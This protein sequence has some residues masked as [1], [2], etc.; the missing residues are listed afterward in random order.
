MSL[1]EAHANAILG[2]VIS[3]SFTYWALPYYGVSQP[4][5]V[6]ATG[7]TVTFFFLSTGRAYLLR[8]L[9]ARF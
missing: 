9:F 2:I 8:R 1:A 6:S 7:I 4:S 5:V 3:W